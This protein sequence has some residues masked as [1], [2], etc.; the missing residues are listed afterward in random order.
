MPQSHAQTWVSDRVWG[1]GYCHRLDLAHVSP[2]VVGA[3]QEQPGGAGP[4]KEAAVIKKAG[5]RGAGQSSHSCRIPLDS[6]I[7]LPNTPVRLGAPGGR[8]EGWVAVW[9]MFPRGFLTNPSLL[10]G[11]SSQA[12]RWRVDAAPWRA[13][14]SLALFPCLRPHWLV[15]GSARATR[16]SGVR[17]GWEPV[18]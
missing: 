6:Q 13:G 5:G 12:G 3:P 9:A 16:G 4:S 10:G 17:G 7:A 18:S 15:W 14:R 1:P 8:R 11:R 2:V